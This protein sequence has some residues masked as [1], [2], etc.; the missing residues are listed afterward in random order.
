MILSRTDF[1]YAQIPNRPPLV[2]G[3]RLGPAIN[4]ITLF[5]LHIQFQMSSFREQ[6]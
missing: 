5:Y 2:T 1:G 6:H 3:S 4:G